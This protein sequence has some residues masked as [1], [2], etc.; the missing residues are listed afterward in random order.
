MIS[1]EP[2]FS[3][4]LGVKDLDKILDFFNSVIVCLSVKTVAKSIVSDL[5][6]LGHD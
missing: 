1:D 4:E 3:I 5:S 6:A 2:L